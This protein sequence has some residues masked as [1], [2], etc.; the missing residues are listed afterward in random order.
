MLELILVASGTAVAT[1]LGA[2]PVWL[3][4]DRA[5]QLRP[6]LLGLA[7]GVMTVAAIAGLLL[8]AFDDG[9]V[10]EVGLGLAAGVAFLL[11]ARRFLSIGPA[12][13]MT[14][15]RRT[16]LL[17]FAVLFVHSLPEG[18][19]IGT[20]YAS[21][22][23]GLA[24]FIVVAIAVQNI[25]E[26]TSVAIPMAAAGYGRAQQFWAAVAT[27]APQPLGAVIAFLLVEQISALL[28]ISFAFAAGAMLALVTVEVF[29]SAVRGGGRGALIGAAIGALAMVALSSVLGV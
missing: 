7:A 27:S 1:G 3:L 14:G 9:T 23:E 2:I 29:P 12:E 5:A 15:A 16:S 21:T 18:L 25:P 19:A 28:P 10:P 17:V 8:P 22:T 11:G 20:A 26:G 6:L 24:L 4:G 13:A